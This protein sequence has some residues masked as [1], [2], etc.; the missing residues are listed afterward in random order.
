MIEI[1]T[2]LALAAYQG[3]L[4]KILI[5]VWVVKINNLEW[6]SSQIYRTENR[7]NSSPL[8]MRLKN[9]SLGS[10]CCGSAVTN[11]TSIHE[12]WGSIPGLA[13][14]VKYPGLP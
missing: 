11:L 6:V 13:H 8:Q 1:T 12:D 4:Q 2:D 3:I 9:E 10:S 7:Y 5:V 14:W